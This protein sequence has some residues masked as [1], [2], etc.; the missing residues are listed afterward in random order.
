[1]NERAAMDS[2]PRGPAAGWRVLLP[3]RVP[4]NDKK[5]TG[6][7]NDA[8][9]I[10]RIRAG[11]RAAFL[12]FYDRA[13]PLLLAVAAR[14]L[15]DRREAEDV[16]QDV[17]AQ[18]WQK[19]QGFDAELGSLTSWTCALTRNK[20]IDRIRASTRRR[21]LIEEIAITAETVEQAP[22]V[23][24]DFAS[25]ALE[26]LRS[27]GAYEDENGNPIDGRV[28][29]TVAGRAYSQDRMDGA[30]ASATTNSATASRSNLQ[31]GRNE[32]T[33]VEKVQNVVQK[34]LVA[35]LVIIV[36][37]GIIAFAANNYPPIAQY[38]PWKTATNEEVDALVKQDKL[39]EALSILQDMK[40]RT[41][42][43]KS[44]SETFGK[45]CV[46][47]A[48]KNAGEKNYDDA[49]ALLQ[50]VPRGTASSKESRDLLKK[51]RNILDKEQP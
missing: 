11:D 46:G 38:L 22:A 31:R 35:A 29:S 8:E 9:I 48:K 32:P 6:G 14:I 40:E 23:K 3:W 34:I 16:L 47:L 5:P 18:L 13:A 19:S 49:I 28:A 39:E 37:G 26:A 44:Q 25:H 36:L 43:N 1:M 45:V 7:G 20:A 33:V 24:T 12:E 2:S 10:R 51:Y 41:K 21:R 42:L 27:S 50:Q 15:N 4:L 30:S 17:F